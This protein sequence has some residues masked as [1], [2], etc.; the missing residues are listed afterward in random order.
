MS[1][2]ISPYLQVIKVGNLSF[3]SSQISINQEINEFIDN[4]I[5]EQT[6]QILKR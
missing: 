4:N 2:A 6:E 5:E 3:I 1:A